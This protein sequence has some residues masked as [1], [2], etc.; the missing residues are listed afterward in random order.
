MRIGRPDLTSMVLHK[1]E[2]DIASG[3][4]DP[5]H[6]P[7][8]PDRTAGSCR[9][10]TDP[11][12]HGFVKKPGLDLARADQCYRPG[13]PGSGSVWESVGSV[14]AVP[15]RLAVGLINGS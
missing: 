12:V 15:A 1:R 7:L 11:T 5:G 13:W 14:V 9:P 6:P 10:L 8:R 4:K 2:L 3:L